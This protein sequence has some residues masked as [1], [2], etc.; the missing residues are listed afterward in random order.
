MTEQ[1]LEQQL[2]SAREEAEL[3]LEQLHLVQEELEVYFLKAQDLETQLS[4]TKAS[5]ETL[6]TAK[7][8]AKQATTER[9]RLKTRLGSLEQE[10]KQLKTDLTKSKKQFAE[11]NSKRE[12][13]TTKVASL[14]SKHDSLKATLEELQKQ[15]NQSKNDQQKLTQQLNHNNAKLDANAKELAKTKEDCE[16]FRTKVKELQ[17]EHRKACTERDKAEKQ[18]AQMIKQLDK[19]QI[20]SS[21]QSKLLETAQRMLEGQARY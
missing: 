16:A 19:A 4:Q 15:N 11:A 5:C 18:L 8:G 7:E 20:S 2:Q 6:Q 14:I 13:S 12:A 10:N 21:E 9:D 1:T 3:T 17:K